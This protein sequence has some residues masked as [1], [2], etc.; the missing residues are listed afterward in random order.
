MNYIW[1]KPVCKF[2]PTSVPG[3]LLMADVF[4]FLD[5]YLEGC[6]L[7]KKDV[8]KIAQASEEARRVKLL[9]GAL[10]YLFRNRTL[11]RF[12]I[13]FCLDV[14]CFVCVLVVNMK[15]GHDSGPLR[16]AI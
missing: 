14:F 5:S 3:A 6:L 7:V 16:L 1:L 11:A 12:N 15:V 10:R 8:P 2:F 13:M 4:L 9:M